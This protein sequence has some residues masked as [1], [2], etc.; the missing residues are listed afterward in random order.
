MKLSR[1]MSSDGANDVALPN[2]ANAI[3]PAPTS[4]AAG[5]HVATLPMC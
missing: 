4:S 1:G 5:I 3:A 2:V